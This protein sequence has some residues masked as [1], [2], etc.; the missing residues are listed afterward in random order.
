MKMLAQEDLRKVYYVDQIVKRL[1]DYSKSL[2][3]LIKESLLKGAL[4]E[5]GNLSSLVKSYERAESLSKEKVIDIFSDVL[6]K[7]EIER[8][9]NNLQKKSIS[10][11][12]ISPNSRQEEINLAI[13]DYTL[14]IFS[15][16]PDN[17]LLINSK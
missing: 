5:P 13:D 1:P 7:E 14:T 10:S 12:I 6:S 2:K 8:R 17:Q 16:V 11:L 4:V 3:D 9:L 15:A